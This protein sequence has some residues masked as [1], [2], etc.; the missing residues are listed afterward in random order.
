MPA[1][2]SEGFRQDLGGDKPLPYIL[3]DFRMGAGWLRLNAVVT[4][5]SKRHPGESRGPFYFR[6]A[7]YQDIR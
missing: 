2:I 5:E 3:C 6:T 7:R 1:R 4:D